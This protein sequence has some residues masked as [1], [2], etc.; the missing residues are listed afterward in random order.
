MKSKRLSLIISAIFLG[1]VIIYPQK[2]VVIGL[3]LGGKIIAPEASEVLSHYC[4][5]NGD[6]LYLNSDCLKTS[7]V[8]LKSIKDLKIGQSKSVSFK[9]QEDYRLYYAL[10]PFTIKST[11][12]GFRITQYIEFDS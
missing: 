5:G 3:I 12:R 10:N 1:I 9:Q 8:V 2:A 11:T 4:F 6:T 7:P